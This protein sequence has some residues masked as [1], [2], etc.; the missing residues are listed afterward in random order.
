MKK[1]EKPE[2]I[3]YA[4]REEVKRI[5]KENLEKDKSLL[6]KLAKM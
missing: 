2:K 3:V 6:E 5:L 1:E 4:S